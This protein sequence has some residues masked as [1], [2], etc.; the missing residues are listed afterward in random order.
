MAHI[1]IDV[2]VIDETLREL[3]V[4]KK[5]QTLYEDIK[6]LCDFCLESNINKMYVDT[7]DLIFLG[8]N[9]KELA[10]E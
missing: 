1:P 7:K 3:G 9:P 6:W 5:K 4:V 8:I 10:Y 2:Y